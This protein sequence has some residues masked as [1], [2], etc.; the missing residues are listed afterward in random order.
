[1]RQKFQKEKKHYKQEKQ[2]DDWMKIQ[3]ENDPGCE[4]N[5]KTQEDGNLQSLFLQTS[6]MKEL[7]KEYP[8]VVQIDSTFKLNIENFI[9]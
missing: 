4:F 2:L 6:K 5:L 9:L 7:Y 3:M 8:E 1:M